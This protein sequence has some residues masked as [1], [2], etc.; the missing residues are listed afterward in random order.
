M[1]H[2]STK[3]LLALGMLLPLFYGCGNDDD[4][5][6]LLPPTISGPDDTEVAAGATTTLSFS[7]T[8]GG[9]FASAS[10]ASSNTSAAT[11]VVTT[12]PADDSPSGTVVVTVTGVAEGETTITLTV[13]D[14][15]NQSATDDVDVT[16]TAG[17]TTE[18]PTGNNFNSPGDT[19]ANIADLSSL[20][21]AVDTAGLTETLNTAEKVTIFAPNN[22]AFTNL[23]GAID[24]VDD[25]N[26]LIDSIGTD[27]LASILQAHVVA[28]SLSSVEVAAA[29]GGDSLQ[30]L[31]ADAKLGIA[32]DADGNLFVNGARIVQADIFTSNGVIHVIDSVIN[33]PEDGGDG[34]EGG[35]D[36]GIATVGDTLQSGA[37]TDLTTLAAA[38]DAAEL[39]DDL[40]DADQVTV[41]APN[42]A[43]FQALLEA[44]Q[45]AD[46]NGL[47]EKL[48][49]PAVTGILQAHVVADS[50]SSVE[51]AAAAGG[52]SLQTLNSSAKLGITADADG[53]LFVNGARIIQAD[54]FAGNGVIHIIDS[55]VNTGSDPAVEPEGD[56]FTV[57]ITNVSTARRYFQQG[58]FGDTTTLA[59]DPSYS[60]SFNAGPFITE[61]QTTRLSFI[62]KLVGAGTTDRF[63]ATDENGIL[64]YD[65]N[66]PITEIPSTAL[67]VYD[68]GSLDD[69]GTPV[70]TPGP[71]TETTIDPATIA[72][73]T[74]SNVG[75]E[76]TVTITNAQD[77]GGLSPGVYGVHT[78]GTP[79]FGLDPSVRTNGLI[80]LA[81]DGDP[82]PLHYVMRRDVGFAVPLSRG[83]FAIHPSGVSP[84]LD[85]RVASAKTAADY[86]GLGGLAEDG[87]PDALAATL[88]ANAEID[89]SGTFGE[90][91]IGPGGTFSFVITNVEPGDLLSLAT[92]MVQ[93]N[94]IVYSTS[95][96]GISL[97]DESDQPIS[98]DVTN[99][100]FAYDVGTEA[101][102]YPGAGLNQA[103]RQAAPNTGPA[104]PNTAIRRVTANGNTANDD[105]FVYNPVGS[106]IQVTITPN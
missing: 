14:N 24:N 80:E 68:A 28:D 38:V 83:A 106:R 66:T 29:A 85:P 92:M 67:K 37:L 93:S 88:A 43:A 99:Q 76:F 46:L 22:A 57:T 45:V 16:V 86:P 36:N 74:I 63:L 87:N 78:V 6:D 77:P 35:E 72:T 82:K 81:E 41:F 60:F 102:E 89:S 73:V 26:G 51:A 5:P 58:T 98:G 59:A 54:I 101:N 50:L 8:T 34:G 84:I 55:V 94:D 48:G 33:L 61:G 104:D 52:D 19:I 62:T 42:N 71:V 75:T 69:E 40:N 44:Q 100:I 79:I 12:P 53:N 23:I 90:A 27:G 18:P 17:D 31:N 20:A 95:E 70:A 64:L 105:G 30:T 47:V 1:R 32:A 25:L 11:A 9:G 39:T 15:E 56:G 96:I 103:P 91:P 65:G 21:A 7:V 97:Y 4:G 10:V 3:L 13:N 49:L 2:L